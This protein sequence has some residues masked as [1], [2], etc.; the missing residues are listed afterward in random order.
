MKQTQ[1]HVLVVEDSPSDLAM[2][3]AAFE[4]AGIDPRRTC[5][6]DGD[7]A[8]E[9]LLGPEGHD[10]DLVILDINL[11]RRNGLEVLA[12]IRANASTTALTVVM[13]TTSQSPDD[14]ASA[15]RAGANAYVHKPFGVDETLHAIGVVARFWLEVATLP[16]RLQTPA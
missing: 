7:R 5:V 8:I 12:E 9:F 10:V 13:L 4:A 11:P 16:R 14:V 1:S 2:L 3:D 15:Y 6:T